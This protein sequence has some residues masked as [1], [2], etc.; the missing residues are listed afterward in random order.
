MTISR[1]VFRVSGDSLSCW[2]A[3][4]GSLSTAQLTV[5]GYS[6]LVTG[7]LIGL[8]LNNCSM[9]L[10]ELGYQPSHD[11]H[12]IDLAH[13]LNE[14]LLQRSMFV[15]TVQ[16]LPSSLLLSVISSSVRLLACPP[17]LL[18]AKLNPR[19]LSVDIVDVFDQSFIELF[20]TCLIKVDV[21]HLG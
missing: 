21:S 11:A 7:Q 20:Q 16:R 5:D 4:N 8:T 1:R 19:E 2:F 12:L 17:R 13:I 14:V 15:E 10:T 6:R 18:V 3:P 9:Y